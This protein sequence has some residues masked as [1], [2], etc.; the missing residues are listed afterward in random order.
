MPVITVQLVGARDDTLPEALAQRLADRL[1]QALAA[2]PGTVWV[3]LETLPPHRYAEN[4]PTLADGERPVFV[5]VLLHTVPEASTLALR[6]R[7]I[8][9]AVAE[10]T[11]RDPGRVH[12]VF[13]PAA[14]G[15]IAFGGELMR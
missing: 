10:A 3:K 12:V 15:R 11:G 4:G 7:A 13:E 1:G 8:A 6:A 9:G 5:A 2:A 14:A